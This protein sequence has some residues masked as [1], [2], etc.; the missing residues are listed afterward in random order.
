MIRLRKNAIFVLAALAMPAAMAQKWEFGGGVGVGFYTSQ[1][2]T[3]AGDTASAKFASGLSGS[4]WLDN[5]NGRLWAGELRY[6]YQQGDAQLSDS[7]TTA[8]FGAHSQAV[9]YDFLLHATP[10]NA[11]VRPFVAFGAGVKLFQGTGKEVEVQPLSNFALLTKTN[12]IE[13][14]VSIGGGI[15]FNV[16]RRFGFRIEVHDYLSPI[17][18]KV[19]QPNIGAKTGG[20]LQ[21]IVTDFGIAYLF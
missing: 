21:D 15:K 7:G 16:T 3:S 19:I 13:P 10:R 4:A 2:V 12:D 20:W 6:D 17:P 8:K 14:V 5:D 11:K 1:D 18:Q 9:H